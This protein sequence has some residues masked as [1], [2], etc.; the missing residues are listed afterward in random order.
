[1]MRIA[2]WNETFEDAKSRKLVNLN[3]N[4]ESYANG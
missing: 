2:K 1:M 3:S 4:R